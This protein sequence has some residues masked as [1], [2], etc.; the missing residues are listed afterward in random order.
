MTKLLVAA[1]LTVALGGAET[2]REIVAKAA[3]A[4]LKSNHIRDEYTWTQ[5]ETEHDLDRDGNVKQTHESE[6]ETMVLA[7]K[8]YERVI[9]KDGKPLPEKEAKK[10]QEKMDRAAADASKLSPEE[11]QARLQKRD[12]EIA[13]DYDWLHY[14][15]DAFHL[16]FLREDILNGRP[17]YVIQA[18]PE[19]SYSGKYAALFHHVQGTLYVD[20]QFYTVAKMDAEFLDSYSFG[21]FLAKVQKGTRVSFEQVRVNDEVWLPKRFVYKAQARAL[22]KSVRVEGEVVFSGY[23]RFRTDSR[24]ISTNVP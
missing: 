8:R 14:L 5:K 9:A 3:Q 20:R 6:S 15:A 17:V 2:P 7:G 18:L 22:V 16:T 11:L 21:L 1:L 19:A 12:R 23:K 13:K 24:V 10:E 4:M